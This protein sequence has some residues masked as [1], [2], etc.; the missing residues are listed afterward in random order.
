MSATALRGLSVE[1]EA[2]YRPDHKEAAGTRGV[3]LAHQHPIIAGAY[4]K[5]FPP[6]VLLN[7]LEGAEVSVSN[8]PLLGDTELHLLITLQSDYIAMVG[9]MTATGNVTSG[10]AFL[11]DLLFPLMVTCLSFANTLFTFSGIQTTEATTTDLLLDVLGALEEEL[12]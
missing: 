5:V 10:P 9:E 4:Q 6:R 12:L 1:V 7:G 8:T 3:L 2:L 11:L